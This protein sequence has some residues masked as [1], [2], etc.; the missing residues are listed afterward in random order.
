[1][2]PQ[3][4]V[5]QRASFP[6]RAGRAYRERIACHIASQPCSSRRPRPHGP[7][8]GADVERGGHCIEQPAARRGH[9]RVH[10]G[11]GSSRRAAGCDRVRA[12]VP[13][14]L[15]MR[16]QVA[17]WLA[18]GGCAAWHRHRLEGVPVVASRGSRRAGTR[19]P[20][21]C[22]RRPSP[23]RRARCR[24]PVAHRAD[25]RS[26]P[27]RRRR[28]RDGAAPRS[29]AARSRAHTS[30]TGIRDEIG[31][32]RGRRVIEQL[33]VVGDAGPVVVEGRARLPDRRYAATGSPRRPSP[34]R[35][36]PSARRPRPAGP[37]R[38]RTRAAADGGRR[39]AARAPQD[40]RLAGHH[41]HHRVVDP[42]R[43]RAVMRQHEVRDAPSRAAPRHR[44]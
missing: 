35:T 42:G 16:V 31:G 8:V 19:R 41:A 23:G 9:R 11:C 17:P 24:A 14:P 38:L 20:R 1:M 3:S 29:A 33:G 10:T 21:S 2:P 6:P 18:H 32:D 25:G 28:A 27:G 37:G 40:A 36:S 43:D 39:K 15:Q 13:R 22:H 7:A 12:A 4:A 26:R 5:P 30:A 34:G 44:R